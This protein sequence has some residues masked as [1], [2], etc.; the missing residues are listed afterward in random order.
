MYCEPHPHPGWYLKNLNVE[1]HRQQPEHSPSQH[2]AQLFVTAAGPCL[3]LGC[4]VSP[5]SGQL[6]SEHDSAE[7]EA[8]GTRSEGPA[9]T[10]VEPLTQGMQCA[11]NACLRWDWKLRY[12]WSNADGLFADPANPSCSWHLTLGPAADSAALPGFLRVRTEGCV[13]I[14]VWPASK[15]RRI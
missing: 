15:P 14:N 13:L 7:H 4:P 10:A 11:V 2:L 3:G 12:V 6:S 9:V 5:R 8:A 1:L